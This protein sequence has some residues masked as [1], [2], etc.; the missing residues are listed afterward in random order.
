MGNSPQIENGFTRIAN[1]ILEDL[2]RANLNKSEYRVIFTYIRYTYGYKLKQH[3]FKNK[4]WRLLLLSATKMDKAALSK[5]LKSLI[6]KGILERNLQFNKKTS[7]WTVEWSGKFQNI[8]DKLVVTLTTKDEKV[9]DLTTKPPEKV[10]SLTT[11]DEK[12][13]DLT[14]NSDEKSEILTISQEKVVTLTTEFPDIPCDTR[15]KQALLKKVILLRD[16]SITR[17]TVMLLLRTYI[18]KAVK[19]Q[20]KADFFLFEYLKLFQGKTHKDIS[21]IAPARLERILGGLLEIFRGNVTYKEVRLDRDPGIIQ[22]AM[23]K[24]IDIKDGSGDNLR[25]NNLL[26]GV[27]REI[28]IR[29]EETADIKKSDQKGRKESVPASDYE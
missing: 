19:D 29:E 3:P 12:V 8:Q 27:I 25:N 5:T 16:N 23:E 22:E 6:E 26:K 18:F 4:E 28:I 24:V 11:K 2:I 13:V 20:G 14:T 10:V 17:N 15:R 9:V 1:E 21:D 7:I